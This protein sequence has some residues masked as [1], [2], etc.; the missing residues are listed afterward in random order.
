MGRKGGRMADT[1]IFFCE[2][3]GKRLTRAIMDSGGCRSDGTHLW[4]PE[5]VLSRQAQPGGN[6]FPGDA[7]PTPVKASEPKIIPAKGATKK[8]IVLPRGMSSKR[9]EPATKDVSTGETARMRKASLVSASTGLNRTSLAFY[10]IGACGF[11][12]GVLFLCLGLLS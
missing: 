1:A 2:A 8:V 5:C 12:L 7:R 9:L 3:C 4:C 11:L 10:I 6:P